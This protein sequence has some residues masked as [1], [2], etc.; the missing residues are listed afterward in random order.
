M[1]IMYM[2][3][4]AVVVVWLSSIIV[5]DAQNLSFGPTAGFGHSFISEGNNKDNHFWPCYNA[6]IKL[7]Y[8][9]MTHW[10]ISADLKFS[11]EGGHNSLSESGSEY[12]WKYRANYV[13]IPVQGIYFFGDLGDAV[14]PK[15]SLGPS[16]GF[17]VGG[18]SKAVIDE[19]VDAKLR[20]K[21]VLEGFDFGVT[22][23]IGANF[24]LGGNKWLNAD[25]AYYHGIT[26]IAQDLNTIRNRNLTVNVGLMFPI[27]NK[28]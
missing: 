23:A 27:D 11:G 6:G 18:E 28:K 3:I 25:I 13:R 21:D 24:R 14:R 17:L 8:S 16:M 4:F 22:A 5:S 19:A 9:V 20:T 15:L 12:E 26:N 2:K 7:V 1:K 10:G